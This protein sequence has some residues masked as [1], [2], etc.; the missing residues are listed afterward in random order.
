MEALA[1]K[2]AQG[3]MAVFSQAGN[4]DVPTVAQ[5]N[6]MV[7]RDSI[8]LEIFE[9][10]DHAVDDK[11]RASGLKSR[12]IEET[13]LPSWLQFVEED[14]NVSSRGN[15][16]MAKASRKI[17]K[18]TSVSYKEDEIS[19]SSDLDSSDDGGEMA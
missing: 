2:V 5:V 1:R 17:K 7:G 12:L 15:E 14:K 16:A 4:K 10:I 8:E 18:R 11:L 6:A 3:D 13:E 9:K 19:H